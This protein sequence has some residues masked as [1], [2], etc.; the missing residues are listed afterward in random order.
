MINEWLLHKLGYDGT[1]IDANKISL[2]EKQK[3]VLADGRRLDAFGVPPMRLTIDEYEILHDSYFISA[4][5]A[6][7]LS[8]LLGADILSYFD[9]TFKYSEWKVYYEFRKDRVKQTLNVGEPFAHS[10]GI[11]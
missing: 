8:F 10:V 7:N 1:W 6:P 4:H 9:I 11:Q 2:S 5:N 3:P